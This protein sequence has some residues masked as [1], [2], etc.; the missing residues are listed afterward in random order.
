MARYKYLA[1]VR[2]AAQTALPGERAPFL[3]FRE[4]KLLAARLHGR[5]SLTKFTI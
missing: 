3:L 4:A 5:L 1:L 2:R